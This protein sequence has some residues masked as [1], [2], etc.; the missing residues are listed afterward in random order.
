MH[1][2]IEYSEKVTKRMIELIDNNEIYHHNLI[3]LIEHM[4][5]KL[6][7]KSIP[8]YAIREGVSDR[9][10][11]N[12]LIKKQVTSIRLDNQTFMA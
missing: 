9:T 6:N 4:F 10:A 11:R 5:N 2:S 3:Q 7:F 8:N 1:N 12:R